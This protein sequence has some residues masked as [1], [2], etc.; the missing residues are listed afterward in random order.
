MRLAILV[1]FAAAALG[2]VPVLAADQSPPPQTG[3]Q[4]PSPEQM[5]ARRAAMEAKR[6]TDIALLLGL[7]ADQKPAL[8]S[9]LASSR[10]HGM[11]DGR[12][13]GHAP[14]DA[15]SAQSEGTLAALDRMDQRIDQRDAEAKQRIEAT[16]RFYAGLTPDQQQRFDAMAHLM[17]GQFGHRGMG[18]R[19]GGHHPMHAM[20]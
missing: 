4:R 7:R 20:G 1:S 17:R 18:G 14:G 10:R 12:G 11:H 13:P 16:K 6:A 8:D 9:F 15:S 19:D 5:E 2:A 3:W